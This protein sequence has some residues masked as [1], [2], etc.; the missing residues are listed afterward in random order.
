MA[1]KA[2]WELETLKV[3][4][5]DHFVDL[6][7]ANMEKHYTC[8]LDWIPYHVS[9]GI[10]ITVAISNHIYIFKKKSIFWNCVETIA[11]NNAGIIKDI[12]WSKL[13]L[14]SDFYK[15]ASLHEDNTLIIWK[16]TDSPNINE[17]GRNKTISQL[18]KFESI[19]SIV[20]FAFFFFH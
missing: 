19:G 16:S 14:F 12:S 8:C 17:L 2:E 3:R 1:M 13:A 5:T 6:N 9:S 18:N 11:V 20:S 7:I 4:K 15:L 10:G